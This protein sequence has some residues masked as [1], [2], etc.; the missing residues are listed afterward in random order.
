MTKGNA[1]WGV[2]QWNERAAQGKI[3][4]DSISKNEATLRGVF[5]DQDY[6]RV[7]QSMSQPV[8]ASLLA[9]VA[10]ASSSNTPKPA[11]TVSV[12]PTITTAPPALQTPRRESMGTSG[13][14]TKKRKLDDQDVM[15]ID[16]T[17]P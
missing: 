1:V 2:V 12:A 3:I 8:P 9:S 5:G 6:I 16:L 10:A 13:S 11:A 4:L 15:F 14:A 7:L 17:T